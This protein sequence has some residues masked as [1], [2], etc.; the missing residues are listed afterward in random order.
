MT[1]IA[2]TGY[3]VTLDSIIYG[4][5]DNT[6]NAYTDAV[7]TLTEEFVEQYGKEFMNL[8]EFNTKCRLMK[9][10]PATATL[11]ASVIEKGGDIPWCNLDGIA[12]L[13]SISYIT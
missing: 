11:I 4:V 1:E 9:T 8:V 6:D 13:N 10:L 3:I 12:K 5:G 2:P 7:V